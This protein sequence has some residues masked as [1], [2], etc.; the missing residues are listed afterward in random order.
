MA[1]PIFAPN[2]TWY[3]SSVTRPNIISIAIVDSYT[4]TG[5]ETESWDASASQ[6]GSLMVYRTNSALTIAGNGS[7][8][9]KMNSDS[10]RMF[11]YSSAATQGFIN[12]TSI[13]GLE[14]LDS[15]DVTSMKL[16]FNY[17]KKLTSIN[18]SSFIT[19]NVRDFTAMFQNCSA[20]ISVVG[21][22]NFN[23]SQAIA[24][25]GLFVNCSALKY[26]NIG[27][28]DISKVETMTFM[29]SKCTSLESIGDVSNWNTSCLRD[30]HAAF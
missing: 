1:T 13:T 29:L 22:E 26:F 21:L 24:L 5:S 11:T 16:M 25:D 23:T 12:I 8:S 19:D 2:Y 3:K 9:I 30:I 6:D 17:C 18:I 20:L 15:S 14:I 27:V 10:E 28:W 7:G 4:P